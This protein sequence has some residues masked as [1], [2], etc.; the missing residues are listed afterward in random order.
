MGMLESD[1]S[2]CITICIYLMWSIATKDGVPRKNM[3]LISYMGR[4]RAQVR[5]SD[6]MCLNEVLAIQGAQ[7]ISS[8]LSL[9]TEQNISDLHR[10][11]RPPYV[12]CLT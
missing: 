11:H 8:N 1:I 7:I 6:I 3:N 4:R 9:L 2:N 5:K 10:T 12:Y